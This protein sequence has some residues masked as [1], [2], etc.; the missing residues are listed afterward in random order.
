MKLKKIIY[1]LKNEVEDNQILQNKIYL[2]KL[3]G[4]YHE[5]LKK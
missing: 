5:I 1:F 4:K 3:G 2:F